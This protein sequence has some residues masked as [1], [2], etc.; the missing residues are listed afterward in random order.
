MAF[1]RFPVRNVAWTAAPETFK[2]SNVVERGFCRTCGT[3][4]TYRHSG[5]AF[6]SVTL[7]SLDHPEAVQPELCFATDQK[8]RWLQSLDR[9]PTE[10]MELTTEPGF[11]SH[12]VP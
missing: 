12:Q 9:L 1:V 5:S 7:N 6:I 8:A 11:I 4:L 2:S 10:V 3:P